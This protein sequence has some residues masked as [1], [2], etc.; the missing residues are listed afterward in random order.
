MKHFTK[1]DIV[2]VTTPKMREVEVEGYCFLLRALSAYE[3]T[4]MQVASQNKAEVE[5]QLFSLISKSVIDDN[6]EYVFTQD[7]SKNLD[8]VIYNSLLIEIY[9]LNQLNPTAVENAR[10]ELAKNLKASSTIA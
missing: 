1:N 8:P 3:I 2:A 10:Q 4:K 6:N 9:D 5:E 7:E